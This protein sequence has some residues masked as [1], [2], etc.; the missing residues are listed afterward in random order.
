MAS[1][2]TILD[3]ARITRVHPVTLRQLARLGLLPGSYRLGRSWRVTPEGLRALRAGGGVASQT[4]LSPA[5]R[6]TGGQDGRGGV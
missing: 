6:R 4:P 3:I 2:F 5:R 1:D